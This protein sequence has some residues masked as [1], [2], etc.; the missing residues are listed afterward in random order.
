MFAA[1]APTLTRDPDS[2]LVVAS[3]PA[4][5]HGFFWDLWNQA[6]DSWHVQRTTIYDAISE[7]LKVDLEQ[8]KRL[9]PD[10]DVFSQEYECV[11]ASQ[12]SQM[13]DLSLLDFYD[14][15]PPGPKTR[16]LGLDVG[17]TSDRTA[18]STIVECCGNLYVDDIV[19]LN[20]ASYEKQME[21][22][23][24]LHGRNHYAAGYVDQNG[25]GSALSEFITKKISS[26]IVGFTWTATNKTPCYEDLRA[27]IF[28][29]KVKFNRKFKALIEEDFSNVSRIVSETGKVSFDAGRNRLGHSD[30]TSSIVLGVQSAKKNPAQMTAPLSY[31][32]ASPFGAWSSRL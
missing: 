27:G 5:K 4:G 12:W 16:Y 20:R 30:V 19:V 15:L 25:I 7:G 11:F 21:I 14:E 9:C 17:A 22:T 13:V 31:V 1:I 32:R 28:D 6:D 24:E 18:Y 23:G 3:T 2:E 10:P 26:R 29:H 8:L